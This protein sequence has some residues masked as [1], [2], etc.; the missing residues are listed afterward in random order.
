L[1]GLRVCLA[2]LLLLLVGSCAPLSGPQ[3]EAAE[4]ETWLAAVPERD[5]SY[6][7][8]QAAL[9]LAGVADVVAVHQ[10][11]LVDRLRPECAT[12]PYVIP[13]EALWPNIVPALR[14][15]RDHVK[16]AVGEVIV[17]SAYRDEAFNTCIRGATL[18]A[19]RS[20]HAL[21]LVPANRAL[22]RDGLIALLCP[23]HE[24]AGARDGIGLGIYTGQRFH[25]DARSFR[26][27]GAD[28]RRA[29]FPCDAGT[30]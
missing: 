12:A 4:F 22:G 27:W 6:A 20:F 13:D 10:L 17:V 30:G 23:I 2:S 25:I 16:P 8:F 24:G 19:H 29:T 7:R 28:Y 18:S 9:E 3:S 21:D 1:K 26:G 14:F 5:V 15:I 11:W